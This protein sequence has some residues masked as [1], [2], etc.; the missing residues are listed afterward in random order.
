MP[1][2]QASA[3]SHIGDAALL[4]ASL[5]DDAETR[6]GRIVL[7]MPSSLWLARA[8]SHP[9]PRDPARWERVREGLASA[10]P[11][12]LS[13][14]QSDEPFARLLAFVAGSS[15]YLARLMARDP[16]ALDAVLAHGPGPAVAAEIAAAAEAESSAS[17][18]ELFKRLRFAKRR[19]SL[20]LALGDVAG[21]LT[22]DEVTGAL[23]DLADASLNAA[24]GFALR[25][26][27]AAS[28]FIP[29]DRSAP[30]TGSGL[31]LLAMGK[32]GARELNYSSDVDFVVFF[33]RE[34]LAA[35]G[36]EEPQRFAV[37]VTQGLVKAL[38]ERDADGYVFRVDLRLR[39]DAG[40]TQ[41]AVS[42]EAAAIYYEGMGQN[43]E[44]AAF[45]K[46]RA[47]AGDLDAGRAFLEEM[48]PFVWRRHLDYAAIED[49]HS[50]KRQIHAAHG[51]AEI[52]VSGHDLKLGRGGIRE[53]E[54]F[55]QT[56][57]LILGGRV[58]ELRVS[59]TLDALD[60]LVA[61]GLLEPR[62]RDDLSAAYRKLRR[63][64]HRLQMIAD[65]QTHEL[66]AREDAFA[67]ASYFCGDG[68]APDAF[69]GEVRE[70]LETVSRHYAALFERAPPLG[71]EGGRLVFTGVEDDPGTI[72]TLSQMGFRRPDSA[73]SV[74]RGWHHGR[75]GVTRSPR[76]REALTALKPALLGAFAK[77][78]D[79]DAALLRFDQFLKGVPAG[80]QLF[81]LLKANERLLDVIADVCGSAP[82]LA[83]HLARNPKNLEAL[84]DPG[85]AEGLPTRPDA[86][87]AFERALA[88]RETYEDILDAAR[89]AARDL[90]FRTGIA[91]LRG[92]IDP[93][94]AGR[95]YSAIAEAGLA[96][97]LARAERAHVAAH[98]RVPGG[99]FA[100]VAL[101]R[102]GAQ[103]MTAAS[104]LDL[105]FVYDHDREAEASSGPQTLSPG[106]WYAR[107][108]QR[109]IA[110]I[111]APTAQGRMY[112]VD[113]RLRPS[114]SK[115]PVAVRL[116]TFESYHAAEAWT[117]ER[118]AMTRARV[119][120]GD[121]DLSARVERAIRAGLMR[122]TEAAA[123]FKDTAEMRARLAKEKPAKGPLDVK[124][125]R[126]GMIDVE[127]VAAAL[128]LAHGQD[129]PAL[130]ANRT[131]DALERLAE[132][133]WLSREDRDALAS[134]YRLYC[135][136]NHMLRLVSDDDRAA[137]AE[138][139][140]R[141]LLLR[142]SKDESLE[143]LEARLT[144]TQARV[145]EIF[146]RAVG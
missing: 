116:D 49:I 129:D 19:A 51:G 138:E 23:T 140:V 71:G 1:S 29:A 12:T 106:L 145:A 107:F 35:R 134:A 2:A 9:E 104:D 114:G 53:I 122:K 46:A 70:T 109:L 117:W 77:T 47:C 21:A 124:L 6:A 101:G 14:V 56:Q 146:A 58:P 103:D 48:R 25:A 99:A 112:D 63:W 66:P 31:I 30:A 87:A 93:M 144:T 24:L 110:A 91:L 82:R 126:G 120:A 39:P 86:A 141:R 72:E 54:F 130:F 105:I 7:V 8:A 102:L 44:R 59:R 40:A 41:I 33:D 11:E 127:F 20:A 57:Q 67:D 55:A 16:G 13:R 10:A 69:A 62:V 74:V 60:A 83:R 115:G 27:A 79:P 28:R 90:R 108:A 43:W 128:Q 113:M 119:V 131:P 5:P 97:L 136:L 38:Q 143:A 135:G 3:R 4:A 121:P 50:I 84:I 125:A 15:P 64:E 76:A 139:G 81:A 68:A 118:L 37:R 137:A 78:P 92:A 32:Y 142:V 96:A 132:A 45:I 88:E 52:A 36:V 22:L 80:V 61:R 42:T 26:E 111:S 34:R 75:M 123:I 100:V 73:S 133:G 98:G 89:R 65:E 85:F 94:E 18:A 95:A 17:P